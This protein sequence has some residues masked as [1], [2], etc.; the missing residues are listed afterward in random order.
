MTKAP[1]NKA[2]G[3][4]HR[5][6]SDPRAVRSRRVIIDAAVALLAEHGFAGTTVEA[7]AAR[8]GAAKTTIY[9]H[10]PDK[11]AVLLAAIEAIVPSATAPDSGSLRGDLVGFGH[12]LVRIITTPPTAALVPA[13]IDAAERDPEIARL[14]ADFTAQRRRPVHAAVQRAVERGEAEDG[15]D[16]DLIDD[17]LLGPIFYRRL[18]SRRPVTKG[19]V[20]SVVDTFLRALYR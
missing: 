20:E 10:W 3:D 2:S 18:L 6:S 5:A 9:R 17:L 4:P 11:R 8:S 15:R 14:L 7:I 16:A 12:D 1:S 19:Y 13:L